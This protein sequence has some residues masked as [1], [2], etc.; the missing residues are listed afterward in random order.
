[1]AQVEPVSSKP[2]QEEAQEERSAPGAVGN[3]AALHLL[4]E[5]PGPQAYKVVGDRACGDVVL[6]G[7]GLAVAVQ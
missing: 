3:N 5:G 4:L 7:L 6:H 1:M 2:S